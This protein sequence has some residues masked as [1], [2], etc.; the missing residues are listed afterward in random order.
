MNDS[1][2]SARKINGDFPEMA[3][4]ELEIPEVLLTKLPGPIHQSALCVHICMLTMPRS[5]PSVMA[6]I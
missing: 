6:A 5:G 1:V 4:F 2:A 3:T